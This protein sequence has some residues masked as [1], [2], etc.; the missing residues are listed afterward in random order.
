MNLSVSFFVK[1][2]EDLALPGNMG[3]C[4]FEELMLE[5]I[6]LFKAFSD[7]WLFDIV[8]KVSMCLH[9][10]LYPSQTS[11]TGQEISLRPQQD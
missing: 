4:L 5:G 7:A 11:V 9:K 8:P 6:Q 10:P 2:R 1:D 3:V